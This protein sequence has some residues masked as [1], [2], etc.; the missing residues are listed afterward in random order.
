M[1]KS[2]SPNRRVICELHSPDTFDTRLG[3]RA[4]AYVQPWSFLT[5]LAGKVLTIHTI[6]DAKKLK[7]SAVPDGSILVG[8]TKKTQLTKLFAEDDITHAQYSKFFKG[9][10][11]SQ[12]YQGR[13]AASQYN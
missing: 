7:C 6:K 3:E 8:M 13:A 1:K 12:L 10:R 2:H 9:V 11:E 4:S 5:K